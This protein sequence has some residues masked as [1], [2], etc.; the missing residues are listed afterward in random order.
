M[1]DGLRRPLFGV[2]LGLVGFSLIA[3][4]VF[5]GGSNE[6][7]V[8]LMEQAK[9]LH[10]TVGN[11]LA[12]FVSDGLGV[13]GLGPMAVVVTLGFVWKKRTRDGLVFGAAMVISVSLM[14]LLKELFARPRPDI[15]P[16]LDHADGFSFPSG[17][18]LTNFTFWCLLA[19]LLAASS[20]LPKAILW[21]FGLGMPLLTALMRVV[22]GVH[23]PTDVAAG[24]CLGLTVVSLAVLARRRL[25]E[26][27]VNEANARS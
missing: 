21:T 27:A 22:A 16:W 11:G 13:F 26:R 25:L 20:R 17:H 9:N 18:T 4:W 1:T 23:W 15:F 8:S 19:I 12:L 2:V 5:S 24:L 7:D 3:A 6:L 14:W 10:G